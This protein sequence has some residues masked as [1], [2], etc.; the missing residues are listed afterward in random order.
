[1]LRFAGSI[2]AHINVLGLAVAAFIVDAVYCLAV[3]LQ[4]ALWCL[5]NIFKGALLVLIKASAAG[6]AAIFCLASVYDNRLLAAMI[7]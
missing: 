3:D 1:M 2:A 6:I 4:A 5:K 7:I